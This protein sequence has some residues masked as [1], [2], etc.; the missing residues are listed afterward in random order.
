MPQRRDPAVADRFG[1]N[2]RRVRRREDLSQEQLAIK[3]SLHRGEIGKLEKGERIPRIDTLIRLAGAMAVPPE[4]LLDGIGWV[5]A[6][7]SVGTFTFGLGDCEAPTWPLRRLSSS[8]G[9]NCRSREVLDPLSA[10]QLG[11]RSRHANVEASLGV[12]AEVTAHLPAGDRRSS[13]FEDLLPHQAMGALDL[14]FSVFALH[15][16][17]WRRAF[18]VIDQLRRPR[19]PIG[20]V[21]FNDR[22]DRVFIC[23]P[24]SAG[25]DFTSRP[26]C[27]RH[28]VG[29][30]WRAGPRKTPD[31]LFGIEG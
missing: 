22:L 20:L 25:I 29:G 15:A 11:S 19:F 12:A 17:G 18:V 28:L 7:K 2:L 5:P 27:T 6:P 13:D 10:V 8:D 31:V 3:A 9:L 24:V 16:F 4:E 21:P 30:R 23:D 14:E 1:R 26:G